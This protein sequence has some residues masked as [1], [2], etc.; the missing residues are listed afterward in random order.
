LRIPRGGGGDK[1]ICGGDRYSNYWLR[2]RRCLQEEIY[3]RQKNTYREREKN[4]KEKTQM[5]K[6]CEG[7]SVWKLIQEHLR[8][9][10]KFEQY[11]TN[12]ANV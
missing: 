8:G 2:L 5:Q 10:G 1:K 4:T 9:A 6:E 11:W 7:M 3:K 12:V